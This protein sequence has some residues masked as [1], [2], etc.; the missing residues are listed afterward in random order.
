[1]AA[2]MAM[3]VKRWGGVTC[4]RN[5]WGRLECRR[6]DDDN[7]SFFKSTGIWILVAFLIAGFV[8]A[9]VALFCCLFF[10]R[11]KS[12][13]RSSSR[14]ATHRDRTHNGD[15]WYRR[16]H[17]GGGGGF[18]D[19]GYNGHRRG[20][21]DHGPPPEGYYARGETAYQKGGARTRSRSLERRRSLEEKK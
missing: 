7:D 17:G 5:N 1:M 8:L 13:S 18:R 16:G 3:H 2:D 20:D 12:R 4:W 19:D 11:R 10:R 6:N 21:V 15:T 9:V 14:T